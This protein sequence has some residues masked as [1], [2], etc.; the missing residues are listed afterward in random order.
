MIN[1]FAHNN[2]L[3][4]PSSLSLSDMINLANSSITLSLILIILFVV[5]FGFVLIFYLKSIN[6]NFF[7]ILLGIIVIQ[8]F[9]FIFMIIWMKNF[10]ITLKNENKVQ[11]KKFDNFTLIIFL[12]FLLGIFLKF[13]MILGLLYEKKFYISYYKSQIGVSNFESKEVEYDIFIAIYFCFFIVSILLQIFI[14]YGLIS[15][16]FLLK[17]YRKML[18]ILD[19]LTIICGY[20]ILFYSKQSNN[21]LISYKNSDDLIDRNLLKFIYYGVI[22]FITI[23]FIGMIVNF[24]RWRNIY[25]MFGTITLIFSIIFISISGSLLRNSD[26]LMSFYSQDCHNL[27]RLISEDFLISSN[28]PYKYETFTTNN[29]DLECP[30]KNIGVVWDKS[31]GKFGDNSNEF[32]LAC[33]NYGCCDILAASLSSKFAILALIVLLLS[34][35]GFAI[36]TISLYL[37]SNSNA[38]A[39]YFLKKENSN[40]IK[41]EKL[42]KSACKKYSSEVIGIILIFL[43]TILFIVCL[44]LINSSLKNQNFYYPFAGTSSNYISLGSEKN[45][46]MSNSQKNKICNNATDALNENVISNLTEKNDSFSTSNRIALLCKNCDFK[47]NFQKTF[48]VQNIKLFNSN[49][50]GYKSKFFPNSSSESDFILFEGSQNSLKYFF[51]DFLEIC[52][53]P[54]VKN[55]I[56]YNKYYRENSIN[57]TSRVLELRNHKKNNYDHKSTASSFPSISST[58]NDVF[59]TYTWGHLNVLI[60]D[61]ETGN[62]LSNVTLSLIS[63]RKT[64]CFYESSDEIYRQG[65]TQENGSL[66]LYNVIKKTYTLIAIKSG[67]KRNCIKIDFS[68]NSSN[69]LFVSALIKEFNDALFY[70]TLE[71]NIGEK[72]KNKNLT[73]ELQATHNFTGITC[74]SS[75]FEETCQGLTFT[76]TKQ[77]ENKLF[78]QQIKIT[79]K[80]SSNILFFVQKMPLNDDSNN[81][82]IIQDTFP[83]IKIFSNESK[84]PI[85]QLFYPFF[86]NSSEN[87][88]WLGFCMNGSNDEISLKQ[89]VWLNATNIS[90]PNAYY[91]E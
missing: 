9:A 38:E 17:T 24:F 64:N 48:L 39:K 25:L 36:T 8:G 18:V 75:I 29:Y 84:W 45:S 49:S 78:F 42:E 81:L 89:K 31:S 59:N 3:E 54:Y 1:I 82:E 6:D 16:G 34:L 74:Y 27:I 86:R 73:F 66:K 62:P 83:T 58:A 30:V 26:A 69:N 15:N 4:K 55:E 10:K 23:L 12:M 65:V 44:S 35:F 43:S 79:K 7:F 56:S 63:W 37:S 13:T 28:C 70:V 51:S 14:I 21:Y 46:T 52:T 88:I 90:I 60:F 71:W 41:K 19:I 87:L 11:I 72:T 85:S 68:S 77:F 32:K 5:E 61:S 80:I 53:Y 47:V 20:F 67:Y 50:E 76:P 2:S 91:C 40:Q 57:Q 22:L 33:L